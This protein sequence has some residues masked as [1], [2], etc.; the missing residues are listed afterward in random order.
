MVVYVCVCVCLCML[1]QQDIIWW[2]LRENEV[3][4]E[5]KK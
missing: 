2:E 5:I 4:K 3:G 1:R